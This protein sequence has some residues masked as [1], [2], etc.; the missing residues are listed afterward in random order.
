MKREYHKWFS[1]HLER[2][3]EL[4]VFGHAG[5]PILF[6]PTRTARFYD[7]EDWLVIDALKKK[8]ESGSIQVWCLDSVDKDS[9]YCKSITPAE[10]IRKHLLYEKY[11][12]EEVIDLVQQKNPHP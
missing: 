5:D 6:F 2:D 4:L 1:P 12:L 10:R 3:M 7:Y 11:V 8:I 9:L